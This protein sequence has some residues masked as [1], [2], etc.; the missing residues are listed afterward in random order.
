MK[1]KTK[2]D[3]VKDILVSLFGGYAVTFLG[4]VILAVLLLMLQISENIVD[5]GILVIYVVACL[6]TGIIVGKRT[7]N[8]KFLWGMLSGCIYFLILLVVSLLAKQSM[9]NIGSD[10]VTT[11]FICAGSG[12]LGGMIS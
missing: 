12:T 10:L 7:K 11:L 9:E 6:L 1:E 8:K 3:Y 4:I 5:V 2:M